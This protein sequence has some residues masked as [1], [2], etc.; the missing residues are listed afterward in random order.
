ME[1]K[2]GIE[3]FFTDTEGVGGKIKVYPEDFLCI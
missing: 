2:V 1:S 3:T